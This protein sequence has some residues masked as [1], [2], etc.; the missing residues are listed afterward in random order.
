M[1]PGTYAKSHPDR[2][3]VVLAD[4]DRR[5]TYRALDDNSAALARVLHDAGL[6]RGDVVALLTD[7]T[8]ESFEVFWA[9]QRSGL[10]ITAVNRHLTP[11]EVAYIVRDSGA[12]ALV[13]SAALADL[14]AQ[15]GAL[16]PGQACRLAFGGEVDGFASYEDAL[17]DAGPR[18][19]DE[20]GGAIMLYSSGTT[21]FPKGIQPPLPDWQVAESGD[22]LAMVAKHMFGIG[23]ETV[24][25]SAAPIY[26]AAPLRWGGIIH[27]LGGTVVIAAKFDAETSLRHIEQYRVTAAQ[28][29]PTMFVRILKLD[30]SVR[31]RYDL[32]SLR[33]LIHAAAP[34][35]QD[36]KQ[37]M[38]DWL[39]PIVYEYYSST[40]A[41]GMTFI[42]SAEWLEHPGS[43]GKSVLGPVHICSDDGT[44]L[45]TGEIGTVYFEREVLPFT[46]H[47]DPEKTAAAQHPEH[48]NWT[49]VG[50]LGYLDEDGYLYLTDRKSFVIISGGVNI[51]PQE[52]E[53]VLA[54]HP[55]V[56]DVAVIGI[57]DPEMG[58]QVKAVVQ[59]APG[60][61][62]SETLAAELID[63]VRE[64]IAHYKTPRSVDFVHE[65]PRTPT[66]KLVKGKI[67]DPY[68]TSASG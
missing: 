21:G 64:R 31:T 60:I 36:V 50:D 30:D 22:P 19:D 24:Y 49:T 23:E 8:V 15:V 1:Y 14:A 5:L 54:L 17:T 32:S 53:N 37:A 28:M 11:D 12:K 16:V 3:A 27:A 57:P 4:S 10:Y 45:S 13:V 66:G 67:R 68:L 62:E 43:V 61:E 51:Y 26:H 2:L 7:N 42:N 58:E 46:Y 38:I 47:N 59:L 39:G 20:P 52:S 44:V 55:A 35:P 9:T 25:Y 65:L 33:V 18:L 41:N 40:E 29:V 6:R 48:P 34:C 56:L 63:Y